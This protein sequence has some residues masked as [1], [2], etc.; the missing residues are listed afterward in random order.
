MIWLV[1]HGEAA[2]G[3]GDHP[4]PGLSDIGIAQAEAVAARLA[5]FAPRAIVSSPMRRCQETA[6]PL[7][8]LLNIR[9]RIE[10]AVSEIAAP[11]DVADRAAWLRRIMAGSWTEAGEPYL[12]WRAEMAAAVAALP[13]GTAV[14]THFVAIN[15]I[16]GYTE[17]IDKVAVFRPAHGSV[18]RLEW[19]GGCLRVA[20]Y[21]SESVTRVL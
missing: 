11:S 10:P 20:E 4:D 5:A 17:G 9:M 2:A 7:E 3:W 6:R 8:V 19:R 15:A 12:V 16:A 14:F 18:T 13:A 1:R 21:G